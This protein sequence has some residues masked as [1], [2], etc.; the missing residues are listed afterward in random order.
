MD[1][2]KILGHNL[3]I[4][5]SDPAFLMSYIFIQMSPHSN[6]KKEISSFIVKKCTDFSL[7]YAPVF[8]PALQDFVGRI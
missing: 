5:I 8:F 2:W 6:L 1:I 3:S 4:K 7:S